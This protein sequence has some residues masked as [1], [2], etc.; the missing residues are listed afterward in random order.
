MREIA[1]L[2]QVSSPKTAL[3]PRETAP[4]W[5]AIEVMEWWDEGSTVPLT[6]P[7]ASFPGWK[8]AAKPA[9]AALSSFSR[10]HFGSL[11]AVKAAAKHRAPVELAAVEQEIEKSVR[12]EIVEQDVEMGGV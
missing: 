2:A 1:H 10:A 6:N 8:T 12:K 11:P 7:F 9:S 3:D 5:G 4:E